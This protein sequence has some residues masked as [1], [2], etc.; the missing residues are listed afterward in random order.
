MRYEIF[1]A[2]GTEDAEK[3]GIF[4]LNGFLAGGWDHPGYSRNPHHPFKKT[5]RVVLSVLRDLGGEYLYLSPR[6]TVV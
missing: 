2:E 3:N 6:R 1:T 5:K 4:S